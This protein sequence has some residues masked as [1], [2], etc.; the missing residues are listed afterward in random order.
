MVIAAHGR[1]FADSMLIVLAEHLAFAIVAVSDPAG[2]AAGTDGTSTGTAAI[3]IVFKIAAWAALNHFLSA[4]GAWLS[5]GAF[6]YPYGA[7]ALS[8]LI[9]LSYKT[10]GF[11]RRAGIAG[12]VVDGGADALSKSI[13]LAA[14]LWAFDG[15]DIE[16]AGSSAFNKRPQRNPFAAMG[17]QHEQRS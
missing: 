16:G 5:A 3:P 7:S 17:E 1:A 12:A 4:W 2:L 14:S 6:F 11:V 8:M 13:V 15:I 10:G 9:V